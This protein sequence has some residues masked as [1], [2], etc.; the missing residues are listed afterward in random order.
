M[1]TAGPSFRPSQGKASWGEIL[2]AEK[3]AGPLE[4]KA[5]NFLK[6]AQALLLPE[7]VLSLVS[8][9]VHEKQSSEKSH[10]LALWSREK[11]V[12]TKS[13]LLSLY[14]LFYQLGGL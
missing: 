8:G 11:E 13:F 6:K 3:P 14:L 9:S 7:R 10:H 5:P 1:G 4:W 2:S 12:N